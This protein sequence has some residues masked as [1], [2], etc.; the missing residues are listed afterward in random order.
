MSIQVIFIHSHEI[1]FD[2]F[3][4]VLQLYL[5]VILVLNVCFPSGIMLSMRTKLSY[6]LLCKYHHPILYL[7]LCHSLIPMVV[8]EHEELKY[9]LSYCVSRTFESVFECLDV[10]DLSA[11]DKPESYKIRQLTQISD[12]FFA[13]R[14][15]SCSLPGKH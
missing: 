11:E 15:N 13:L 14:N 2:L 8:N 12:I 3:T 1:Y 10:C 9:Q 6:V 5:Q 7:Y 4:I